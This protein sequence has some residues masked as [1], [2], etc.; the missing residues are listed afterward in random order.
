[1]T[2]A[3]RA[4]TPAEAQYAV[5]TLASVPRTVT[6]PPISVPRPKPTFSRVCIRARISN[7]SE[8]AASDTASAWRMEREAACVVA[9]QT[10]ATAYPA[11]ESA[12]A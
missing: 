7:R 4:A 12:M 2:A 1:M 3:V 9:N 10:A 5:R 6:K 8:G 11:N